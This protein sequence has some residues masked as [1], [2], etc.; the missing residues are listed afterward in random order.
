MTLTLPLSDFLVLVLNGTAFGTILFMLA[1]GLSITMGLMRILNMAHGALYMV[2]AYVGWSLVVDYK[3]NFWLSTLV[4]G[5]VAGTIGVVIE[6]GFLRKLQ[7]QVNDQVLLTLGFVY[8][9]TNL[10][11][12]VW[13]PIAR[14][15]FTTP[16]LAGSVSIAGWSYPRYRLAIIGVGLVLAVGLWWLQEKTRIGAMIR[17]GIDDAPMAAAIG[18]NLKLVHVAVF[19]VGSFVAGASG[20]VGAQL[21]GVNLDLSFDILLLGIV[22][23]IVG[24]MGST[25]GAL[26]GAILIGLI[27]S[28]GTV[29][30]PDYT[31]FM[32]YLVMVV[33]L[34]VR[35]TGLLGKPI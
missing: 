14:A 20:V 21:L 13:G 5:I 16:M 4:A 22:V 35:P 3:L 28:I 10:C 8:I 26:L 6:R 1:S 25:Q 18:I 29:M 2:G 34:L 30:F 27:D 17:A 9:L 33:V 32:I 11:Q 12:W 7:H 23:V 31:M 24:G 19:F 15:P